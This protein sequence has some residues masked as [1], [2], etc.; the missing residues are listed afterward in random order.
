MTVSIL[1]EHVPAGDSQ[2]LVELVVGRAIRIL[3]QLIQITN[4]LRSHK[5]ARIAC[6]LTFE[7]VRLRYSCPMQLARMEFHG[8]SNLDSTSERP[9]GREANETED[10]RVHEKLMD[11][12]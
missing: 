11:V 12:L 3:R 5:N 7:F 10:A 8:P 9:P 2:P 4:H 1:D 6:H